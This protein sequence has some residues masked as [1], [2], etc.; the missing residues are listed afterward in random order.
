MT[1][2]NV[3]GRFGSLTW[4][5]RVAVCRFIVM[6][7]P[8]AYAQGTEDSSTRA[9]AEFETATQDY[10]LMHR[11]L[12]EKIGPIELGKLA[13]EI[14]RIINELA[15]A[16]RRERVAAKQGDLFAPTL[17]QVLRA[18]ISDAPHVLTD[19]TAPH[20]GPRGGLR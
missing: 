18:R 3:A 16:I 9:V 2:T 5:G 1:N 7:A 13:A 17:G 4:L 14:N 6:A 11:G 20:P 10:A 8:T 12:E 15:T 19:V